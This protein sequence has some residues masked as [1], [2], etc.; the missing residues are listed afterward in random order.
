MLKGHF[1][2]DQTSI[3]DKDFMNFIHIL[4]RMKMMNIDK[5]TNDWTKIGWVFDE[6]EIDEKVI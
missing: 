6:V 5:K 2:F 1:P 3:E 4:M